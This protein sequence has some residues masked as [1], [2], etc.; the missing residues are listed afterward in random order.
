MEANVAI[1]SSV[2]TI[3]LLG[4]LFD[5]GWKS[6]TRNLALL[7][8][9]LEVS[10]R[11]GAQ[12]GNKLLLA[13][14]LRLA[15]ADFFVALLVFKGLVALYVGLSNQVRERSF[16]T[17]TPSLVTPLLLPLAGG[18]HSFSAGCRN[19]DLPSVIASAA[20]FVRDNRQAHEPRGMTP[21]NAKAIGY[22][23]AT[24]L[25]CFGMLSGGVAELLQ[26]RGTVTGMVALG[27]PV[28]FVTI[29]GA[30]KMLGTIA[31]LAPGLPRLKEW[32]YAGIFFNMTGALLSHIA[33][34]SAA[35]HV[36][37]TGTFAAFT[38]ISWALRPAS[39]IVGTLAPAT[40]FR[41]AG[42]VTHASAVLKERPVAAR[43]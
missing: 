40:R 38:V 3:P 41:G 6:N 27:Y 15:I 12:R 25:L 23:T 31:L 36:A 16:A 30:W 18:G 7:E 34:G 19:V 10:P 11:E 21:M 29:I 33:T 35:W 24:G 17:K 37:V 42:H 2:G 13:G 43:T 5:A 8:E 28:Y 22:W 4:D 20:H 9:T 39:R 1:D 26:A 32:A 14:L